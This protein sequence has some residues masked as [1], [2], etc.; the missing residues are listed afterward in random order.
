MTL[1]ASCDLCRGMYSTKSFV[2]DMAV[3]HLFSLVISLRG[4]EGEGSWKC[5]FMYTRNI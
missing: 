3:C 2:W 4:R 5:V 1:I